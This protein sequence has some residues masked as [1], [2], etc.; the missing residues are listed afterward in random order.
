M[1]AGLEKLNVEPAEAEVVV[2]PKPPN[3]PEHKQDRERKTDGTFEKPGW[4]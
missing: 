4:R 1:L 3:A 2:A